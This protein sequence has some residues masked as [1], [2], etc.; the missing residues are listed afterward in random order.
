MAQYGLKP[1]D[2]STAL[3]SQNIEAST[4]AFGQES[5]NVFEY[6]LKYRGRLETEE[7]FGDIVIRAYDDGRTLTLKDIADIELGA[8]SYSYIGRVKGA[9][10]ISCSIN[11]TA[12][13]NANEIIKK[14]DAYLEEAAKNLPKDVEIV[15]I[16]ST[17][18]F[19]DASI[20]EVIKTLL[21]AILLV[22]IVV[23]FFLQNFRS[24]LIPTICIFVALIGTFAF[25]EI[26]RAS[27][28]ERV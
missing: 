20:T 6:T 22:V 7:E 11:Q 18:D 16:M 23:Y 26:G 3:A 10:G 1:S 9:P 15:D 5:D 14:I 13:S 25:L 21:I 27:C 4:G 12:G 2:I 19:L 24:T 28:R 17:K 8:V